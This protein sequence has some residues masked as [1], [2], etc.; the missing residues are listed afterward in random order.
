MPEFDEVRVEFEAFCAGCGGG[1]CGNVDTRSSRRR[2]MSQITIQPCEKC[3]EVARDE[4]R[5]EAEEGLRES[6]ER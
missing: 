2:G 5:V 4:G 1:M 3:L 6:A